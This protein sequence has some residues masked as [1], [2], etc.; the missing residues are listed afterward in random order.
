M[1]VEHLLR[2]INDPST[3]T[4][5]LQIQQK[6]V[7]LKGLLARLVEIR[8]YLDKVTSGKMPINNQITNNL[9]NIF[10]LLPNLNVEELV[11][12]MFVKTNDM[13]LVMY[14]SS[15][16]RA[17]L[18]L[19]GLLVNKIKYRDV[20]AVLDRDAGVLPAAEKEADKS[21]VSAAGEAEDGAAD[22]EKK[23][24]H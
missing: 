18:A 13:H 10:N 7:G 24:A 9:Q 20:D 6:V 8:E 16:V 22:G 12:S 11:Q 19:H 5:A 23:G 1:G 17:I 4:L 15:L 2:D 3:G 14:V 21:P